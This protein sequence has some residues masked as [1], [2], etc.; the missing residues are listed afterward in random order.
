MTFQLP[1]E[2]KVWP[3]DLEVDAKLDRRLFLQTSLAWRVYT[4]VYPR[5]FGA[6]SDV[7]FCQD[8]APLL[9]VFDG[10]DSD[11]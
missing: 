10:C 7:Q 5:G 11:G 8:L 6:R 9:K 4:H 2:D 1:S 3:Q